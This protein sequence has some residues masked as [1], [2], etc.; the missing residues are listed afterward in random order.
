[1]TPVMSAFVVMSWVAFAAACFG[2]RR[3]T[4]AVLV[5]VRV[6]SSTW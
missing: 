3:L 2:W 5:P 1:M 6:K 4:Q